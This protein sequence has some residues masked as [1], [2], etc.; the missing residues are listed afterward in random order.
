MDEQSFTTR[1]YVLKIERDVAEIKE[2]VL[3]IDGRVMTVD[4]KLD[5]H[6]VDGA[7]HGAVMG[8]LVA[9]GAAVLQYLGTRP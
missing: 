4:E 3:R 5:D 2:A 9:F 1:D 6:R 8:G 7:K